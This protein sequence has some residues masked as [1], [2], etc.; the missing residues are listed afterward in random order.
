[1]EQEFNSVKHRFVD[2]TID[3]EDFRYLDKADLDRYL[4]Q[5]T[6]ELGKLK[7]LWNA[8]R[9]GKHDSYVRRSELTHVKVIP[10]RIFLPLFSLFTNSCFPTALFCCH[11]R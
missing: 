3:F 4:S 6:P 9:P 11:S 8:A 5:S 2:P 1:M 10:F 7:R